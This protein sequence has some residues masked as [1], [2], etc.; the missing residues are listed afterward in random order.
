[1][2]E[3]TLHS[4]SVHAVVEASSTAAEAQAETRAWGFADAEVRESRPSLE[5]VF[6]TLT[7]RRMADAENGRAGRP[8]AVTGGRT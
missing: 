4:E 5:D 7:R 1:V 2:R 3:A 8:A 6:V